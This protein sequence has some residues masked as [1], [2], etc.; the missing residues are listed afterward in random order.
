MP[1][2]DLEPIEDVPVPS[3][4]T[5]LAGSVERVSVQEVGVEEEKT[6]EVAKENSYEKIL[7]RA[8]AR[9]QVTPATASTAIRDDVVVVG[10]VDEESRI[11]KLINIAMEKGPEHAFRVAVELDDMYALDMLHDRLSHQLYEELV[12]KGLLKEE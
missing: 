11:Q 5:A 9:S 7:E 4:D 6:P 12:T 1:V 2:Y 8:S 3:K 10:S